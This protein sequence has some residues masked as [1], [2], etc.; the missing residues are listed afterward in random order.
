MS[1]STPRRFTLL[2]AM[3]LIAVTAVALVPIRLYLWE[4]L[5]PPENWSASELMRMGLDA[6][7]V[8][9]PPALALTLALWLLRMKPPRPRLRRVFR[10]PGLA[11]STTMLVSTVA[12]LISFILYISINQDF[13]HFGFQSVDEINLWAR[14]GMVPL[15]LSGGGVAAVWIVLWLSGTWRAE[16]RWIDRAGTAIGVYWV[17]LSVLFGWIF[18]AG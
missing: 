16:P 10:Q 6:N 17:T 2:D 7:I 11:A 14:I 3:V 8:L 9:V 13:S 1:P 18:Y 4:N 5:H 15:F 12:S